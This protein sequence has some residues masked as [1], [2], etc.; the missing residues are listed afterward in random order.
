MEA[1]MNGLSDGMQDEVKQ[2]VVWEMLLKCNG[3]QKS[4][5]SQARR[6]RYMV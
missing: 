4:S 5:G 1:K 6:Q 3:I 2:L